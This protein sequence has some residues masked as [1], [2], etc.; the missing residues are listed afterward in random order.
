MFYYI[1]LYLIF[2]LTVDYMNQLLTVLVSCC[3][4]MVIT[5]PER[6]DLTG[7]WTKVSGGMYHTFCDKKYKYNN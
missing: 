4:T 5:V 3:E 2:D 1:F 6:S 7:T